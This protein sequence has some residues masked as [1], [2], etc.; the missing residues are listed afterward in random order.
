MTCINVNDRLPKMNE[1]ALI[2]KVPMPSE[3]ATIGCRTSMVFSGWCQPGDGNHSVTITHSMPLPE[4]P[5]RST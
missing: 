1:P 3:Q 5:T 2:I 4:P